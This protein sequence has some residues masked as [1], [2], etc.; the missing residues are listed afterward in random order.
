MK[1]KTIR[2]KVE[3]ILRYNP[4]ARN[5]DKTL[6]FTF[7]K[8]FDEISMDNEDSFKKG[9]IHNSTST[10]SIRRARQLIQEDG[11]Y[12]PDDEIVMS[13]RRKQLK[14]NSEIVNNREVV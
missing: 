8:E 4:E 3:F 1:N 5:C 12:L 2:N 13:R 6:I 10:E 7:W 11:M 14:M 9:F